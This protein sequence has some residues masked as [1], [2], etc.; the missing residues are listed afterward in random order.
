MSDPTAV[1]AAGQTL[2]KLL[3]LAITAST[4]PE[5]PHVSTTLASPKD[6]RA[7]TSTTTPASALSVWL[8]QVRRNPDL[9]NEPP[10]RVSPTEVL[11]PELPID[12]YYLLTPIFTSTE[13]EQALL[14]TVLQTFNDNAIVT[15]SDLAAPLD[16]TTD[17]LRVSLEALTLEEITRVWMALEE[18][19][20]LSVS[21]HVQLV[22]ISSA[23]EPQMGPPVLTR[24]LTPGR[25]VTA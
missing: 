7:S 20:Q 21:Y 17:Q 8:Y 19:Y 11:A 14:G 12:L 5:I 9:L 16:P 25:M 2:K 18:S 22:R 6:V 10:R 1:L 23:R 4:D 13:G 3:D 15:G 24:T